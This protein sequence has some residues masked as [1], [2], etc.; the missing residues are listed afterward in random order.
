MGND[1]LSPIYYISRA[2]REA[3][4][5]YSPTEKACL[6]LILAAQKLLHYLLAHQMY[7]VASGNPIVYFSATTIPSGRMAGWSVQLFEF[8][9]QPAKPKGIRGQAI[10]DLLAAFPGCDTTILHNDI[11]AK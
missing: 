11:L 3:E 8:S 7:V 4:L 1:N 5:R 9:L 10:A 6:P 2:L